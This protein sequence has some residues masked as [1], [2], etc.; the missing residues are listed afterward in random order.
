MKKYVILSFI[1]FFLLPITNYEL[2][3]TNYAYA[4]EIEPL[5]L[6]YS[7]EAGKIYSGSFHIRNSSNFAVD[8]FASTGGYRYIFS[9]DTTPPASGKKTL[10]SCQNWLQFEKQKFTL[11]SGESADAKFLIKVPQD[12]K[13]EHLCAVLFD[14]KRSTLET[15][16]NEET[17]N[18]Q[19]QVTPR[20]SIPV[21]VLIKG[22]EKISAQIKEIS[23]FSE[24]AKKGGVKIN[25]TVE[26]TGNIHIRPFGTL[27][28]FNQ[29]GEVVKN[30]SIGKSLPIFPGYKETIS[31]A[32]PKMPAGKY[33]AVATVEISKDNIIQKKTTFIFNKTG[34]AE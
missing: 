28:I 25:L 31:V 19:I 17:G 24:V 29:N 6:E 3:I 30:L 18:V 8:I 9:E 21:Y 26:N 20:F 15:K 32:C 5:R 13:E 16:L 11:N 2:Q 1:S 7:L 12:A 34:E 10:P 4:V 33:S 27:I 22:T 23:T 14:E